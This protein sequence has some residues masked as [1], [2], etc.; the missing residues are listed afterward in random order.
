LCGAAFK[1]YN[2]YFT[3]MKS[4]SLLLLICIGVATQMS[5]DAPE[6]YQI[7]YGFK[8]QTNKTD[9]NSIASEDML[10]V[11]ND[12]ASEFQSYFKIIKDSALKQMEQTRRVDFRG[13]PKPKLDYSIVKDRSAKNIRFSQILGPNKF[14]YTDSLDMFDWQLQPDKKDIAG[15]AC[16]KATVSFAGRNYTAWYTPAIPIAEG[17]YKFNGLPGLI[18][19]V[20]DADNHFHFTVLSIKKIPYRNIDTEPQ[21]G[22]IKMTRKEY[23]TYLDKIRENPSL[24]FES[25][26]IKLPPEMLEKINANGRARFAQENNPL[27]I[28]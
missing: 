6:S 27:E 24:M 18:L 16:N 4:L 2:I 23:R 28:Y 20:Y 1:K 14:Y 15:Y 26:K 25:D 17:P 12:N 22:Y 3:M 10:L 21:P 9:T 11:I 19:E 13:I 8:F 7:E 5:T